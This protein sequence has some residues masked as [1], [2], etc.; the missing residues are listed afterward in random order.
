MQ[1]PWR[2]ASSWL[3]AHALLNLLSY[4]TQDHQPGGGGGAQPPLE[5]TPPSINNKENTPRTQFILCEFHSMHP[6]PTHL[7]TPSFLSSVL[8][9]FPRKKKKSLCGSCSVARKQMGTL[10]LLPCSCGYLLTCP[11]SAACSSL[12]VYLFHESSQAVKCTPHTKLLRPHHSDQLL[13][14]SRQ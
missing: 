10:A 11:L 12:N 7:P 2:G 13:G 3:V 9:T 6:N 14:P 1:R 5:W 4:A 8:T